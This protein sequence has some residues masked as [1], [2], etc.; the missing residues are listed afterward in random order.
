MPRDISLAYLTTAPMLPPEALNLAAEL[1]YNAVGLRALPAIIGGQDASP[2]LTDKALLRAT[3]QAL[4]ATG[5]P[6]FDM[7][8]VRLNAAY[9]TASFMPFLEACGELGARAI[10]V[11][12]DDADEARLTQSFAAFCAAARPF[13]LSADLEPMP[14]TKIP[15]VA[16]AMR[17]LDAAGADNGGLLVDALHTARSS[18]TLADVRAI[19]RA[20]IHYIQL[21]DAPGEV[22]TTLEGLLHTARAERLLPGDGD[23][24]LLDLLD[25]LPDDVPV[26]L[27]IPH[28]VMRAKIGTRAW[29]AQALAKTRSLLAMR[30]G[31]RG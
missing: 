11:A 2:L 10:L 18:T 21:C 6:V 15:N 24:P 4:A 27:E 20:R 17:I 29:A 25:A 19:P 9:D 22:P 1:G 30:V 23:L 5:I 13:G 16:T 26:S 28:D 3:R 12:G 14:W 7:E 31:R 8:I